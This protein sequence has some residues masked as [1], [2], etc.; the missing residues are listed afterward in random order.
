MSANKPGSN[1][2]R[3]SLAELCS[4]SGLKVGTFVCEFNTPGIGYVLKSAGCDFAFIDMEHSGFDVGDLKSMLRYFEA[5]GLPAF[6]RPPGKDNYAIS[7]VLDMGAE[8]LILPMVGSADEARQIVEQARY[9]P[10]GQRGVALGIAH[11]HYA[12]GPVLDKLAA[13]NQRT[14]VYPLIETREGLENVEEIMAVEGVDG[15]WLGHFDL[16]CSLGIPGQFDHPDFVGAVERISKAA[17]DCGKPA[18]RVAASA[19]EGAA[20]YKAGFDLIAVSGDCWLLQQAMKEAADSIRS[21]CH[22]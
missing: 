4:T 22:S 7:R 11:D 19:E 10:E 13:A 3:L 15:L 21:L 2:E 6:V 16:S 17:R 5:A 8:G 14:L 9:V 20:L 18:A 12:P 1:T